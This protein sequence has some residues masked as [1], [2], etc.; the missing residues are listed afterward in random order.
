[1]TAEARTAS[2]P[3]PLPGRPAGLRA[4]VERLRLPVHQVRRA[5]RQPARLRRLHH[6]AVLASLHSLAE[7]GELSFLRRHFAIDEA[8]LRDLQGDLLGDTAFARDIEHR[9]QRVRGEEIR[10]FGES[11]AEDHDR[12]CRM[13]YYLTRLS[14]PR[15]VVET[16]VFDGF[17]SAFILKALDDNGGGRLCS[18]DL[19]AYRPVAASTDKML[20]DTLPAGQAPGWLVPDRLRPRWS[21][22]L[23]TSA[24]LLA[25][26]LAELGEIDLFLHDSLHTFDNMTREYES[27]WSRLAEEGFLLSDDV[28]WNRAFWRFAATRRRPAAVFRG[29]GSIRKQRRRAGGAAAAS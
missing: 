5:L 1:M 26:W 22:R 13:L 2:A 27:A 21:L 6:A 28:F 24:E 16:G 17:T 8:T 15:A 11:A 9:H 20:H 29:I 18:I 4:V 19:P 14:R 10:L 7:G 12:G 3:P 25:P 23:G